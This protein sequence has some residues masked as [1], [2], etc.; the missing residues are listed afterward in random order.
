VLSEQSVDDLVPSGRRRHQPDARPAPGA[1]DRA[2]LIGIQ[3]AGFAALTVVL[4]QAHRV[5]PVDQVMHP[6]HMPFRHVLGRWFL[7]DSSWYLQIARDGYSFQPGQQSSVAF[8]P[9]YPLLTRLLGSVTGLSLAA[10]A[11]SV[12]S[13]LLAVQ[14]FWTW[15]REMGHDRPW[16]PVIALLAYPYAFFLY[17][18]TYSDGLFLSV[19]LASFLAVERRRYL[20]AGVLGAVA[21]ATR[22]TGVC[23]V[24]GL[25]A[26]ALQHERAEGH[27]RP[28]RR[29]APLAL[30]PAGLACWCAYLA[31]RFG[32]P[33]AFI[34]VESAPGWDNGPGWRT[35]MKVEFFRAVADL[36]AW[37]WGPLVAQAAVAVLL[38]ALVPV[39]WRRYGWGYGL[40]T[41]VALVVPLLSTGDFQGTGRYG[42]SAFPVFAVIGTYLGGRPAARPLVLASV[43]A[44]FLAAG[45]S[46][47]G[48][49]V[50]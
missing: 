22:P 12:T 44:M 28:F 24:L 33:L 40:Y 41:A 5:L 31:V 30:S 2:R 6:P 11:L 17:G 10:L 18:M 7:W 37:S 26:V 14:L 32:D 8:F 35:W 29:L 43:A 39:V 19:G 34:H 46:S 1:R 16:G 23:L 21:T 45:M 50:S 48:H 3:V 13:G 15:C 9:A 38:L 27:R 47:T 4:T 36:D 20:L 49:L 25:V 42:L